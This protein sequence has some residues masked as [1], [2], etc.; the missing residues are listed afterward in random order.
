MSSEHEGFTLLERLFRHFARENG[1]RRLFTTSYSIRTTCGS[2]ATDIYSKHSVGWS[3]PSVLGDS[4]SHLA[5]RS[6]WC[7]ICGRTTD[8]IMRSVPVVHAPLL[9]VEPPQ[10]VSYAAGDTPTE[11]SEITYVIQ[12]KMFDRAAGKEW[13][14]VGA[15]IPV[16]EGQ[17]G[18]VA[19]VD[20]E[21][22]L[23]KGKQRMSIDLS[24]PVPTPV[25]VLYEQ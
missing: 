11:G 9:L 18:F 10:R 24:H 20:G 3:A 5:P 7:S 1:F 25:F 2:C 23:F 21:M 4:V 22:T 12:G 17:L 13:T 8:Q 15:A 6:G 14:L 16:S 19:R